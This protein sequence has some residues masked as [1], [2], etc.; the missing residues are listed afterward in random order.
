MLSKQCWGLVESQFGG[1]SGHNLDL[2]ASDS[3]VQRGRQGAPLHHFTPYPTPGSGGVNVFNQ[4]LFICD[5]TKVN[6]YVFSLLALI[7]AVLQLLS[8][9][10]AV[11][12]MIVPSLSPFPS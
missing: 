8:S 9:Q 11:V 3:N 10:K 6:A 5:R 7:S 12:T 2:M 4:N 1:A